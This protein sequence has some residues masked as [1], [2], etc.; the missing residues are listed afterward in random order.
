MRRRAGTEHVDTAREGLEKLDALTL[1]QCTCACWVASDPGEIEL[2]SDRAL[3]YR[4]SAGNGLPGLGPRAKEKRPPTC[5]RRAFLIY[6]QPDQARLR[7]S[8]VRVSISILS[9]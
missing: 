4:T 8:P 5:V 2:Q 7:Y 9:P 6:D 3:V 1:L